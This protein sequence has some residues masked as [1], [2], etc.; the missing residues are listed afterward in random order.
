MPGRMQPV[1][2]WNVLSFCQQILPSPW[3]ETT[4]WKKR[5]KSY[6]KDY[7]LRIHYNHIPYSR[8]IWWR[9]KFG[10]LA[11]CLCNRQIKIRQN[12]LLVY[13]RMVI[14]YR[15][16]KLKFAN[17]FVHAGWGQ[18]AKFN[19]RQIF[20]LYDKYFKYRSLI[21]LYRDLFGEWKAL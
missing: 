11:V 20:R 4:I 9:I 1:T 2:Q 14:L 17:I 13:I 16:A 5:G 10:G 3:R 8:K 19:S 7:Q 12:F 21:T 6:S 15:T 18:S